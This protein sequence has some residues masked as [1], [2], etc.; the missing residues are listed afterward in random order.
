M[1][2]GT[3]SDGAVV[4]VNY[5]LLDESGDEIDSSEQSQP[6]T[7]LHGRGQ[8]LPGLERELDGKSLGYEAEIVVAPE[9]GFGLHQDE[10]VIDVPRSQFDFP[11]EKGTVVEAQVQDG[12]SRYLQVL[13]VSDEAVT[14]DGNHPMAGKTLHFEVTVAGLREATPEELEHGHVHGLQ[15]EC[16][17]HDDV[18]Q[19]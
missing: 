14:L 6:I 19:A 11:V 12:G 7:Y 1:T 3:V 5:R 16:L 9:D 8:I 13:E 10:L 15:G 2:D 17:D 18:P 4:V